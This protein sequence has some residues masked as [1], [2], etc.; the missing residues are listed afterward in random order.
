VL[1]RKSPAMA[2]VRSSLPMVIEDSLRAERV[3]GTCVQ[4]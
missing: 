1:R 3:L 4:R 2:D